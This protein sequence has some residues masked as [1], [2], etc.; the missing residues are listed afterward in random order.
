MSQPTVL[1]VTIIG[2]G[3]GGLSAAIALRKA[4]HVV[5]VLERSAMKREVGAALT[6][7]PNSSLVLRHL[8]LDLEKA[9]AVQNRELSIR[10]A[11]KD[12]MKREVEFN[13]E[14]A[15]KEYGNPTVFV[16]RVDLHEALKA[17][18]F[19]ADGPGVPVELITQ[20]QVV[21]VDADAGLVTLE[22]GS[23]QLSDLVVGA[24]GVHS[25]SHVAVLGYEVPTRP[26]TTTVMRF[27]VPSHVIRD[28]PVAAQIMEGGNDTLRG[29]TTPDENRFLLQYPC[30]K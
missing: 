28:D 29:Y 18:A 19:S 1:Q 21:S 9:M 11:D 23:T 7:S 25:K 30:R 14:D 4:G 22:D 15:E 5:K 3:I 10:R 2:A 6:V 8:G 17:K 13:L 27:T 20:A 16:H 26:S 24:D 12:I